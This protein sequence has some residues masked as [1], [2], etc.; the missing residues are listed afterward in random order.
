[1][2]DCTA[3]KLANRCPLII[4]RDKAGHEVRL[5]RATY[6]PLLLVALPKVH[7]CLRAL[8]PFDVLPLTGS[9]SW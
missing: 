9:Y 3:V 8:H 7:D 5:N 2:R 1:M 4:T 6:S